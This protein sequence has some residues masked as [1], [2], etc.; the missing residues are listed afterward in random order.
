MEVVFPLAVTSGP[1][2]CF[3]FSGV[4]LSVDRFVCSLLEDYSADRLCPRVSG[5]HGSVSHRPPLLN[6]LLA[7]QVS[8]TVVPF[9]GHGLSPDMLILDIFLLHIEF[10][11]DQH[12][13]VNKINLMLKTS[14]THFKTE[15]GWQQVFFLCKGWT[16]LI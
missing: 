15:S 5:S 13:T 2:V 3:T 9:K 7:A 1:V 10:S 16:L 14:D 6:S 12:Y 11:F 4:C 8:L